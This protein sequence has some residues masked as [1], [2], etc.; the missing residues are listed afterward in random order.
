MYTKREAAQ[1]LGIDRKTLDKWLKASG[2]EPARDGRDG[3]LRVLSE[4]DVRTIRERY[5]D[6]HTFSA[7]FTH[8]PQ[9]IHV[10]SAD[11]EARVAELERIVAEQQAR[12][13]AILTP[14]LPRQV[15][16]L[17]PR[18]IAT[19]ARQ[20]GTKHPPLP[21]GIVALEPYAHKHD[22]SRSTAKNAVLAGRLTIVRDEEYQRG[23]NVII[24]V[25]DT[26]GQAQWHREWA[27]KRG[28]GDPCRFCGW[29]S[30]RALP[31]TGGGV[32]GSVEDLSSVGSVEDN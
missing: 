1:K 32:V 29:S 24:N 11:L 27:H 16:P 13:D 10:S 20:A 26:E 23:G 30:K 22:M 14:P 6:R 28:W 5:A 21:P 19:T 12:L 8:R 15:T 3:R 7:S 4:E 2:I 31:T 9:I 17:P 25:L 18:Q